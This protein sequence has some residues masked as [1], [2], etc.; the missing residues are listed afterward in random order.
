MPNKKFRTK[1]VWYTER[2]HALQTVHKLSLIHIFK[3]KK[4]RESL[5]KVSEEFEENV[6]RH[7]PH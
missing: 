7:F 6:D 3:E 1:S 4:W 5:G 2:D